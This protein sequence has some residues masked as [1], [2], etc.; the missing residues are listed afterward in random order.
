MSR[1]TTTFKYVKRQ[2][3]VCMMCS[4]SSLSLSQKTE[5]LLMHMK[6]FCRKTLIRKQADITENCRKLFKTGVKFTVPRR[7]CFYCLPIRFQDV[8]TGW[9]VSESIHWNTPR[10]VFTT[11][12]RSLCD[13]IRLTYR[14]IPRPSSSLC[15]WYV[16]CARARLHKSVTSECIWKRFN[17][18]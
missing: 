4:D 3:S 18:Q 16:S 10:T 17:K 7:I 5:H 1:K 14:D 15:H 8:W 13:T 6:V 11:S 9:K 12:A 2:G